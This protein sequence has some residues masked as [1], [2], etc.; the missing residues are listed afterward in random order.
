MEKIEDFADKRHKSW[1]L[2]CGGLL[3]EL[4]TNRD[5]APSQSFL[6][7]PRPENLPMIP[8]C[9]ECNNG[10]SKDEAYMVASLSSAISGTTAPE[11]QIIPSARR[12]LA[13]SEHLQALIQRSSS[14]TT[15]PVGKFHGIGPATAARFHAL[16]IQT[17]LDIRGQTLASLEA[18][19][20]KAG[21]Y[22]YWI[23]R[24]V[25]ERPVRANRIRKSV[26]AENTFFV[27]L[28]EFES[29]VV[30]LQ[31]LV[32][33]VWRHCEHS[34]NR[35]RTVTL[36]VKFSDFE[37]MSRS[38]SV[39]TAVGSRDYLER[40]TVGL[41]EAALPLPKAV[42]LLG[43]SLSSLQSSNEHEESQIAFQI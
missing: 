17:G 23:S 36:K 1:C 27:D 22:Y 4:A 41:L 5:H 33:K 16:G 12:I 24:G 40:L 26:G 19:F 3:V 42:R 8:A 11:K 6:Q 28:T 13:K 2:Y 10:F 20:G 30:E 7:E 25:D 18:H 21:A 37:I 29:M 35:G 15:I 14:Y 34:G 9:I 32:D 39:P 43:V 38:R 31:P